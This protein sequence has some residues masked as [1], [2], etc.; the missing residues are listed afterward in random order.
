MKKE[1]KKKWL[2]ITLFCSPLKEFLKYSL[3]DSIQ[4]WKYISVPCSIYGTL[5]ILRIILYSFINS[6][7]S[8]R[9]LNPS[10]HKWPFWT[11]QRCFHRM[12]RL[13]ACRTSTLHGNALKNHQLFLRCTN[14]YYWE[15]FRILL[16][17]AHKSNLIITESQTCGSES[18]GSLLLQTHSIFC[19]C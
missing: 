3:C 9:L 10:G 8:R 5:D 13:L 18:L 19:S 11:A 4:I 1:R 14:W 15:L 16:F 2:W 7:I 17:L 6:V 12:P